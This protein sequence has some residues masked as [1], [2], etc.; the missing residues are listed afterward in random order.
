M[1]WG[2]FQIKKVD[3]PSPNNKFSRTPFRACGVCLFPLPQGFVD[4][5]GALE[6]AIGVHVAIDVRRGGDVAMTHQFLDQLQL[7]ALR[8]KER[9]AGAACTACIILPCSCCFP[10]GT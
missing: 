8:D 4:D 2:F 7:H 10:F 5:H 1:I 9:R 3:F 6:G